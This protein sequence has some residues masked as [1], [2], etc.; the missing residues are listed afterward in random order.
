MGQDLLISGKILYTLQYRYV[1]SAS[2]WGQF[3]CLF[4]GD[5]DRIV[6]YH[7]GGAKGRGVPVSNNPPPIPQGKWPSSEQSKHLH[8]YFP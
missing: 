7:P 1:V 8:V 5:G 3:V 4:L 6:V 2:Q